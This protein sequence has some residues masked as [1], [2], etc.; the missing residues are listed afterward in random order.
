MNY[1]KRGIKEKQKSLHT[2]SSK[3][4][5]K[6]LLAVLNL[7]LL[8]LL[9][10]GVIGASMGI[11]IFRGIIDT[12]PSIENI[13]VTPTGFSTFVYDLEGNQIGKLIAQDSNRIPVAQDMIPEDLAH[14][15]VAVEDQRFYEHNGIDVKGIFRSA[16]V[17]LSTGFKRKEG[18]STITQQLL[19]NNV[20]T[21]WTNEKTLAAQVKRKLQEQYL[22][23]ELSKTMSKDEVLLNYMNTINLGQNTLGVQAASL[24]YFNKSV[25]TLT[26]SE[27]AVIAGITQNPSKYNPISH[28]DKNAERRTKVLNDMK[29]QGYITQ[30][31]YDEAMADDVYSR[32][33]IVNSEVEEDAVNTYFVDA[34]TDDVMEDLMATGNYTETQAYTLLYSGGLKIYA[35]QDPR[36][37]AI[38]D[39]VFSN[40]ENYPEGTRW[41]LSYELT[42]QKENGDF[43]NFSTEM[44]KEYFKEL[45]SSFNLL[46]SNQED[47]Y[48]A[49]EEYKAAV[50]EA[51][52]EVY[53]ENITLT[54]QPQVSI[55]VEDQNTGYVV[56]MVGGRGK[57]E[58]SRTLNRATDTKRQPG[59]TFKIV[60]VYAP[61]LDSAGLTLAT[62][63]NDAPFN[64]ADGRPVSNWWGSEYRG[65]NSLRK[66]I[67]QSMNIIAVKTLTQITPQLGFDYLK[68]F[69]YTTLVEREEIT[70]NGKTQVFS[71]IQQSLAL[72]GVTRGVTNEELTASYAAIANSGTYIKPKL[73]TKVLD[74]DGNVILDNT[75]PQSR[76]VIKETTA[77]LLTDAMVDVVTIGTGAS[78]NFGN[79]AIAGKTGTTSDYNDV[80]FAGYTPYYTAS[81]WTGYDNNTKLR[82]DNGERNLAKKLWRATMSK[83]HEDLPSE[84][85]QV[86]SGIVTATVCS[87]SGKLPIPGLCDG[88]LATEYFA[89]GTVPTE[90]C[91]VHYQGMVCPYSNLPAC[92]TCPFKAEGVLTMTPV[93]HPAL[94]QGS[95]TTEVPTQTVTQEITNED[96]SVSTISI[97]QSTKTCI[98]TPE[99]MAQPGIEAILDQ[100]RGE[101]AAASAAA[102]AAAAQAA[103]QQAE[104]QQPPAEGGE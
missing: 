16:Y 39:E 67:E 4:G 84:S 86:P 25:N 13:D 73:Y 54:P 10:V 63:Q 28:P 22:A 94:Q 77:W 18:A 30:E 33:Q 27:C 48:A 91:D 85:F 2:T 34:L 78:V 82:K 74:H 96:G 49:I 92:E 70:S 97:P 42:I 1:S 55:V 56:A 104:Q 61:A 76:Q 20:F 72:G 45:D 58:G 71:D 44:Y 65:L 38:C 15:F 90:S 23:I 68:N 102:Q 69:G 59:S 24:R 17:A 12:A 5:K 29:E 99:Y 32:I 98:H 7:S 57:K 87:Q 80:W 36:I 47:A 83:I 75:L 66:G 37:Q 79:M 31:E 9:A 35:T 53:G 51:G 81:V 6:L 19:K 60:A 93:E 46:Y 64:Y 21:N 103:A 8:A 62:V 40:E 52:D 14:A 95:G 43:Q 100:Q 11:G 89:E 3:W 26:L 101:M 88:T 50:M 41:Q